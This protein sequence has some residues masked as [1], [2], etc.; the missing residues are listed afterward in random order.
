MYCCCVAK[1]SPISGAQRLCVIDDGEQMAED[2]HTHAE[3]IIWCFEH[4]S[5]GIR[6]CV[7]KQKNEVATTPNGSEPA[8]LPAVSGGGADIHRRVR[9]AITIRLLRHRRRRQRRLT[10]FFLAYL[11]KRRLI[12]DACVRGAS[13]GRII[14]LVALEW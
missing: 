13:V 7:R 6:R 3:L 10:S 12:R 4:A 1:I 9:H 11:M 2:T 5:V 14:G 8:C